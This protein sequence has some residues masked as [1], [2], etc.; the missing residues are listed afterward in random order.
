MADLPKKRKKED[1]DKKVA[2]KAASWAMEFEKLEEDDQYSYIEAL[3]R[4]M[5]KMH[6][7]FLQ[8]VMGYDGDEEGDEEGEF[9]EDGEEDEDEDGEE[10]NAEDDADDDI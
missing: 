5:N 9:D 8:G 3:A 1:D 4:S 10:D 2:E 7:Q 6:M